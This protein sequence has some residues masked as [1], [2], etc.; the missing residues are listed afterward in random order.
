MEGQDRGCFLNGAW[1]PAEGDPVASH[2]PA[3]GDALVWSGR[4][5]SPAQVEAAV[6]SAQDAFEEWADRTPEDRAK[7]FDGLEGLLEIHAG[8]L[9][10]AM[11]AEMGKP[12][13]EA[14]A[15]AGSL[16]AKVRVSALAQGRLPDLA[17]PNA[18][19]ESRW[20]PLGAMAVIGP[21][22]YPVHLLHTHV[23][24]ALLAGNTVV[25]KPSEVTP[26]T[27]QIYAEIMSELPLPAGVFNML[28]GEGAVG[29]ALAGHPGFRGLAF[30][31]SWAT[32]RKILEA[33]LDQPHKLVALEMG[34]RNV[35][36]V[37]NDADLHQAVH[38]IV[39]GSCLTTGQR[40]TATSR[41]VVQA[42]IAP[43]LI[44]ALVQ[45]LEQVR[46]GDPLKEETLMGPLASSSAQSRYL[47]ALGRLAT[48]SAEPLLA[49]STLPGG[50]FVTPSMHQC[51]R[52]DD[53]WRAYIEHEFFGPDIALEVVADSEEAL[54]RVRWSPY[55]LSMSV[56]TAE[57][58]VFE[59]FVSRA[60]SG[61][62]NWNR[63]TNNASGLLPFGGVGRSGNFRPAGSTG[64]L[65]CAHS[66]AVLRKAHGVFD[67]DPRF[68]PLV[69]AACE[70]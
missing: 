34:G 31:G 48:T 5:A 8:R 67:A 32:G 61:I 17:L 66:I 19:G 53:G 13:R 59:W 43:R 36:V 55:G 10:D 28:Q 52:P 7:C 56:F 63:S 9:A 33:N 30:T 22:N 21:Y 25:V 46:P 4:G 54:E 18:P 49:P 65:Y 24:P 2:D 29:A 16:A 35:A 39:L 68:G 70:E 1:V 11:S 6:R 57:E 42:G 38:E 60:P 45:A 58:S 20:R 62:F 37:L 50:A 40:C 69:R 26:L 23:A 3:K 27:G 15:E 64:A 12:L 47:E 51:I 41:V 44:A 14:R